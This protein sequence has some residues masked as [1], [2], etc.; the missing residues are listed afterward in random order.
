MTRA[1]K[2]QKAES[3]KPTTN[4]TTTAKTKLERLNGS[5]CAAAR[6]ADLKNCA[7]LEIRDIGLV[8]ASNPGRIAPGA[9]LIVEPGYP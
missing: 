9:V 4:R 6:L 1:T 7:T 2:K 8:E 3:N 5:K